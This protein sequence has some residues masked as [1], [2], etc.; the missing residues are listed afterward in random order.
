MLQ[1]SSDSFFAAIPAFT[2]FG[3][4]ADPRH[5]RKLPDDWLV[6][7]ADIVDSTG[8]IARGAY[9]AVNMVGASIISALINGLGRRDF[10]FVFGGD[11]A[12]FAVPSSHER[13]VR[14][15]ASSVQTWAREEM[16]LALR[17]CLIP[18]ED[19][20]RAGHDVLVARF[21]VSPE[22]AYAMFS[23]G[24]MAWAEG[25][26]KRGKYAVDPAPP[27]TRP[28]LAGLSCRWE[29]IDAERGEIVS[30]LVLPQPDADRQKFAALIGRITALLGDADRTRPISSTGLR[31]MWPSRGLAYETRALYRQGSFTWEYVKLAA[32]TLFAWS[33]FRFN[34][35]VGGFDPKV[36]RADTERNSD[37]RKFDDGL[38]L[39]LDLDAA[40]VQALTRL[41]E[42]ARTEGTA[43]YGLH[44]QPQALMTC[45]VPSPLLRDHLHFIDGGG[46]GYAK[47][48][49]NLKRQMREDT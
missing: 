34:I 29:P 43:Y 22:L 32:F 48:A 4:V 23:G 1:S 46:G 20:R 44:S 12:A 11:G 19:I 41:L 9:K 28:D 13:A 37:F 8:A 2:A 25:Q 31:L 10:P 45:I 7:V 26:M 33:I 18:V 38:K 15:L 39:T 47:A 30:I 40:R 36:Y 42:S 21:A 6:G 35:R 3:E 16:E 49:E 17:V 27:G 24:G 14:D 5:Y